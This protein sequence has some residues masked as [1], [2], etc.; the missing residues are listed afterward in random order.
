MRMYKTHGGKSRY[1]YLAEKLEHAGYS[2]LSP[3][4]TSSRGLVLLGVSSIDYKRLPAT[5]FCVMH[6]SN[7]RCVSHSEFRQCCFRLEENP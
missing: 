4:G 7:V 3:D 5:S 2:Q 1:L 6:C